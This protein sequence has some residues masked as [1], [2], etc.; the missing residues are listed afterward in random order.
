MTT[1]DTTQTADEQAEEEPIEYVCTGTNSFGRGRTEMRAVQAWARF[2]SPKRIDAED[3][4]WIKVT[5]A[6]GNVEVDFTGT[7]YADEILECVVL[8][9]GS[10]ELVEFLDSVVGLM[11]ATETMLGDAEIVEAE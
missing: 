4:S 8:E 10:A 5:K 6:R 1:T 3:I 2:A 11:V 9:I 7:V